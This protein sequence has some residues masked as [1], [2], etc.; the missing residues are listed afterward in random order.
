MFAPAKW[1][2]AAEAARRLGVSAKA[3]R[4]YEEKGLLQPT[5]TDAGYRRY[6]SEDLRVAEDVVALRSLGLSLVQV[7]RALKGDAAA[8]DQA[9]ALR[10]AELCAQFTAM[11]RA[12]ERIRE[13]RNGLALGRTARA[14]ELADALGAHGAAVSFELPWPWGGEQFTLA[15][16]A[17]LTYLVGPLGSGKTQ[18]ALRLSQALPDARYLSAQRLNSRPHPSERDLDLTADE[19]A[20]VE[21]QVNWLRE[22]GAVDLKPLR[23][24]LGAL[25]AQGGRQP[26]V[27][28]L[29]E[30][31]LSRSSQEALM[32][33]LRRRL[34]TRMAPVIAMTRSSSILDLASIGP[35][36]A[37]V[38][39][40]A[41]Q[42]VPFV[43]PPFVG[44]EGYEALVLCLASPEV[45]ERLARQ[46]APSVRG[47]DSECL[48]SG[49]SRPQ[50]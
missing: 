43:V 20:A 30:A 5:R 12:S 26:L 1:M 24:L 22:E 36:E 45:R 27:I 31:G 40:P 32:P 10:E 46:P 25:E 44:A 50:N 11:Q 49:H 37:I 38:Y 42:S 17:P 39:C 8:A 7:A 18:L 14:G 4:L 34:R 29:V 13:M 35:G 15:E 2:L 9:L 19:A 48:R 21:R 16:L 41:N 23:L 3:L 47:R 28:D 6:S 33:L